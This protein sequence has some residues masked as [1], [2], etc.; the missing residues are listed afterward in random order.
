M[1]H[2]VNN[3]WLGS[4]HDADEL[5]RNNP[6]NITAIL[7][8]RGAD[9]YYPPGRDQAA[10]HP[11]KAYKWIPAPDIGTISPKH[12][13]EALL[14][15]REQTDK[16]EQ[17]LI[18]C[19]HGISRSPAFL[20]AFMV[21]SGISPSLEEAKATISVHRPVQPATQ[22][23]EHVRHLK[24]LMVDFIRRPPEPRPA[25]N[26]R[27]EPLRSNAEPS[28][29]DVELPTEDPQLPPKTVSPAAAI[30]RD[31]GFGPKESARLIFP[32]EPLPSLPGEPPSHFATEA[33]T[34]VRPTIGPP[35]MVRPWTIRLRWKPLLSGRSVAWYWRVALSFAAVVLVAMV[36]GFG[37]R[38]NGN[39]SAQSSGTEPVEKI[40]VPAVD[41][42][43]LSAAGPEKDPEK[44]RGRD[45]GQ[46]SAL[47]VSPSATKSEAKD[48]ATTARAATSTTGAKSSRRYRDDLI[49]RDTVTYLDKRYEQHA[50]NR[51]TPKAGPAKPLARPHPSSHKRRRNRS[52]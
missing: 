20:A 32:P 30:L 41:V 43:L 8:V 44:Y 21:E 17:I 5:V 24:A 28:I 3:L 29:E 34:I 25:V 4:Q 27:A 23:V 50:F 18:H 51:P 15:L 26:F 1:H 46:A 42:D 19:K 12:V 48:G 49:A 47:A 35:T 38:Q 10:E 2:I 33:S 14:W 9:A 16:R 11:G 52:E 6:E 37:I 31:P 40:A 7:N 36:L 22:I 13:R 39:A 45:P